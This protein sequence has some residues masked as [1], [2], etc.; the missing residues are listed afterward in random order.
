[1]E[2]PAHPPLVGGGGVS[3]SVGVFNI[4]FIQ[5]LLVSFLLYRISCYFPLSNV[6]IINT[7]Y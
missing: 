2:W 3:G 4:R 5:S 1:M 7:V 6:N